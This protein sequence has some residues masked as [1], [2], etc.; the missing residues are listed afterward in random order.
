MKLFNMVGFCVLACSCSR[1]TA[2]YHMAMN[3]SLQP[4]PHTRLYFLDSS[5]T[6][7]AL[8]N[9]S[10]TDT[11]QFDLGAGRNVVNR[12]PATINKRHTLDMAFKGIDGKRNIN[13]MF[14]LDSLTSPIFKWRG[15]STVWNSV[16]PYSQ[17]GYSLVSQLLGSGILLADKPLLINYTEGYLSYVDTD[18]DRTGFIPVSAKINSGGRTTIR[19]SIQ[20]KEIEFLF[21]TGNSAF[22]YIKES[23]AKAVQLTEGI[24]YER[25]SFD[26]TN[27]LVRSA[28]HA[29]LKTPVQVGTLPIQENFVTSSGIRMNNLGLSF[30]QKFDWIIDADASKVYA[31]PI[32]RSKPSQT[33][34]RSRVMAPQLPM[35]SPDGHLIVGGVLVGKSRFKLG[36]RITSVQNRPVTSENTCDLL[37]VL[38]STP[39]WDTLQI[40]AQPAIP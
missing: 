37:K 13:K 18:F 35:I 39:N 29:F 3:D 28:G 19:L 8:Q 31:K 20:G 32:Q 21:D 40:V 17:C 5:K 26:Y 23:D 10:Q 38:G 36:D 6:L 27:S 33:E 25:Y 34:S 11:F 22:N 24:P 2:A 30:I 15:A 9:G 12:I 14:A 4:I 1:F 7:V 16:K